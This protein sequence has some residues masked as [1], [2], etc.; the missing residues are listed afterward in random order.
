M[1]RAQ[2]NSIRT[3]APRFVDLSQFSGHYQAYEG[4]DDTNGGHDPLP[5]KK[6]KLN[7][8]KR[9]DED[10]VYEQDDENM[11]RKSKRNGLRSKKTEQKREGSELYCPNKVNNGYSETLFLLN[12][13]MGD[14]KKDTSSH[15]SSKSSKQDKQKK[16]IADLFMTSYNNLSLTSLI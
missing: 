8:G 1:S 16:K 5:Q 15:R 9:V 14:L 11:I 6:R 7:F 4:N 3:E 13:I 2:N 10:S 12:D